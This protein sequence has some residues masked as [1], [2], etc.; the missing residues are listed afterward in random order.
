[1]N[2]KPDAISIY[3]A[4]ITGI[5]ALAYPLLLQVITRLETTYNSLNIVKLFKNTKEFRCFNWIIIG[6]VITVII[7]TLN[8][9]PPKNITLL[10]NTSDILVLTTTVLLL[11]N[12]LLLI[13]R[14][15]QFYTPNKLIKFVRDHKNKKQGDFIYS[16]IRDLLFYTMKSGVKR[17][18]PKHTSIPQVLLVFSE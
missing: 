3:A 6:A 11:F 8:I 16:V 10:T 18:F 7:W 9:P 2:L 14:I 17:R 5:L 4:I 15:N 1:M 12:F 13:S